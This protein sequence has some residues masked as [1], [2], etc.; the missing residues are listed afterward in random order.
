MRA[1]IEA[2]RQAGLRDRVRV[3]VGGA[4]VT[5]QFARDIGADGYGENANAA[6]SLARQM[7]A[8]LN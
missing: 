4:P 8:G 5:A 2:I 3:L 1:T 7:M 6:V